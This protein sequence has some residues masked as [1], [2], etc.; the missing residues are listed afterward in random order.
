M[1]ELSK[2]S[3]SP[4][5]EQQ[6]IRAKCFH[7]TG[8]LVEFKEEEIEQAIPQRLERQSARWLRKINKAEAKGE[9][10]WKSEKIT[11]FTKSL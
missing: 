10:V 6:A 9:S 4:P 3:T 5:P 2:V 8:S 1:N 7:P 11:P